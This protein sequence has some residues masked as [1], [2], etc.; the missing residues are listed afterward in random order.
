MKKKK[1]TEVKQPDNPEEAL[2][3][4]D[5]TDIADAEEWIAM[6]EDDALCAAHHGLG[7]MLRNEW[8]LWQSN[9]LTEWFNGIGIKHADDMSGIILV[10]FHRKHNNVERDLDGQVAKY[11]KH[12]NKHDS[13]ML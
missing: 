13:D 12:W 1:F 7:Q 6:T 3:A 10:S 5:E 8:G 11:R 2:A 4:L 9:K